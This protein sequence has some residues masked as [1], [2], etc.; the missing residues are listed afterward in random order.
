MTGFLYPFLEREPG[1]I[2]A[3]LD[4]LTAS[5]LEKE[6]ASNALRLTALK[7]HR[8]QL[9]SVAA[10][11]GERF[12]RGGRLFTFGN[13]GSS[14]DAT[15][16]A[17]LFS[18]PPWGTPRPARAL[19]SDAAVVTALA[20]DVG[21]ELVFSRQLIAYAKPADIAVGMST[22]GNSRNL[23]QAFGEARRR[24]LLTIGLAGY[25]GGDVGRSGDVDHCFVVA[26]DSVHRI[27]E[28]QGALTFELW[29]AVQRRLAVDGG[30]DG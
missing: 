7:R 15:S 8:D 25:D 20:N 5:A 1:D 12:R 26:S 27:Q 3:L 6:A 29:S 30:D 18:S 9:D 23:L 17:E 19:V 10:A 11:M 13:G 24:G 16:V 21:F 4:E 2:D 14:T 22:S 28:T